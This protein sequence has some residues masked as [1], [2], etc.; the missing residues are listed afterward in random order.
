MTASAV[1]PDVVADAAAAARAWLRASPGQDA[2][3]Q[4]AATI[5]TLAASAL[6]LAEAF[7]ARVF[8]MR[9]CEETL[10]AAAAWQAL[11]AAPVMAITAVVAADGTAL[12]AEAYA[13]DI[14]ADGVGWLRAT[15][16]LAGA[17]LTVRYVAGDASSW[18]MLPLPVAQGIVMLV[19]HLFDRRDADAAPPAAV[20]ALWRP[21]R[22]MALGRERRA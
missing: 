4:D 3:D 1:P 2:D 17:R 13:I 22:R 10:A 18:A 6:A 14:D 12:P 15:R 11:T 20:A 9:G 16:P 19:A 21:W 8:V 5:S 7:C